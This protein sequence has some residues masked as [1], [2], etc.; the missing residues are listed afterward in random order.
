MSV[1]LDPENGEAL[2]VAAWALASFGGPLDQAADFARRAVVVH[3][4]SAVVRAH[5]G[6]A[7]VI[8][9]ELEEALANLEAGR[10]MDPLGPRFH[11][12]QNAMAAAYFFQRKFDKALELARGVVAR[13]PGHPV[14]LKFSAAALVHLG[15]LD[16]ARATIDKFRLWYPNAVLS[17]TRAH[18]RHPWMVQ[19][20]RDALRTAGLPE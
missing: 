5:C 8:S 11:I 3:P 7:L 14:S 6:W 16:E 2:G 15:Q 20:Y 18:F 17:N 10:R 13:N 1:K 12:T 9:G 4:N 19:L